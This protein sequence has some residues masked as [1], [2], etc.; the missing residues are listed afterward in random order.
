M[1][2]VVV[3]FDLP[4]KKLERAMKF[5]SKVLGVELE[6]AKGMPRRY[7]FFPFA[8]GVAS[9]GLVEDADNAGGRGGPL[10]YISGGEDLSGPLGRVEASGGKVLVPK[11]SLGKNGF[12]AQLEDTEGNRVALHSM[13]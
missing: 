9:G 5:Y 2:N 10:V 12:M 4:V 11:T 13:K 6:E 7:S 8:P 1:E 3:W